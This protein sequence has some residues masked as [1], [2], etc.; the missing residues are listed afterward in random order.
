VAYED[1]QLDD[2]NPDSVVDRMLDA[3]AEQ[4]PGWDP[5]AA[6][7]AAAILRAAGAEIDLLRALTVAEAAS[8][9]ATAGRTLFGV[10]SL[11]EARASFPATVTFTDSLGHVIAAGTTVAYTDPL[12]G[13]VLEFATDVDTAVAA[14]V[15]VATVSFTAVDPGAVY[16]GVPAGAPVELVDSVDGIA[17]IVVAADSGGGVDPEASDAYLDV[18]VDDLKTLRLGVA[19]AY[20]AMI[21]ARNVPGVHRA[22]AVD[23][24]NPTAGTT[25]VDMTVGMAFLDPSGAEVDASVSAAA[26]AYLQDPTRRTVNLQLIAGHPT[27][28]TV[29]VTFTV[30]AQTGYSATTVKAAAEQAVRDYL[31]PAY[32]SGGRLEPPEWRGDA[33]IYYTDV[34]NVVGAVPGVARV[35]AVAINGGTANVT[36]PGVAPL[37]RSFSAASTPSTVVGTV[38]TS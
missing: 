19:N 32:W 21:L 3:F 6:D 34:I 30:L 35:Q 26:V 15:A 5:V 27:Y 8:T 17:S 14:G 33:T 10:P 28:T 4:V 18:L 12:T 1:L 29:A 22:Y 23:G 20:D 31:D 36:L 7:P 38:V 2:D 24:W 37:P 9:F 25:G 13:D 16:N 11:V